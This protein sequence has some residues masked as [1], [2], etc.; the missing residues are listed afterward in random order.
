MDTI[1]LNRLGGIAL[2]IGP[3]LSIAFYLMQPGGLI[4]DS[5]DSADAVAKVTSFASNAVLTS[6]TAFVIALGLMLMIYGF[7]AVQKATRGGDGDALSRFGLLALTVGALGWIMAQGIR[8]VLADANLEDPVS[9]NNMVPVYAVDSGITMM[10]SAAVSFGFL[11]FHLALSTRDDFH[12]VWAL[13]IAAV[14]VVALISF[15]IAAAMPELR[16]TASSVGRACYFPWVIWS[17]ILGANLLKRS[18]Q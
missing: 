8:L 7:Y 11:V 1:S 18:S 6:V 17:V 15:V 10:S 9:I 5:A 12:R 3:V 16:E 14:S 13:V 4:V 2:I